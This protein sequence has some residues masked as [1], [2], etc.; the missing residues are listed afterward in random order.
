MF[1]RRTVFCLP[2]EVHPLYF[3]D[4]CFHKRPTFLWYSPSRRRVPMIVSTRGDWTFPLLLVHNLDFPVLTLLRVDWTLRLKSLGPSLR[5][6]LHH[7][8]LCDW[9]ERKEE[10]RTTTS[11]RRFGLPFGS[12]HYVSI[13]SRRVP[14][15][16]YSS[17]L[18]PRPPVYSR[19]VVTIRTEV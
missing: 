12:S 19:Q 1:S 17:Y 3:P 14:Y 16:S 8:Y 11:S 2:S 4:K 10:Y 7:S 15:P 5:F 6:F 9:S 18:S 13:S